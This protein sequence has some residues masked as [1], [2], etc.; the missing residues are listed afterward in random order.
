MATKKKKNTENKKMLCIRLE[1]Q[2]MLFL[3]RIRLHYAAYKGRDYSNTE[4]FRIIM[5]GII[6]DDYPDFLYLIEF[7]MNN[8][9]KL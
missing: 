1:S 8:R 6:N 9:G 4:I 3:N 2:D 7:I 5:Y